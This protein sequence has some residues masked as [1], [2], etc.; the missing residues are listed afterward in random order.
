MA[1]KIVPYGRVEI[2]A[3]ASDIISVYSL[4][5]VKVYTKGAQ[6]SYWGLLYTTLPGI[7]YSSSAL[8]AAK[9]VRLEAS[10]AEAFYEYGTAAKILDRRGLRG[11]PAPTALNATGALTAAA[12]LSG[13]VTSTTAAAVAGTVPTA[14]VMLA[15]DE[16]MAVG[17][18]FEWSVINTGANAFTVTA[19]TGHTLVGA[20]AV[21]AGTSGIFRTRKNT[22]AAFIT[23][24]VG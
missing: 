10:G 17:E 8:S 24:R 16:G 23:Y 1:K 4:D 20:G 19:A 21:A 3:A 11:Q 22:A 6:E 7:E 5:S 9:S 13:I 14:T 2:E 18:S 12:M 15:A